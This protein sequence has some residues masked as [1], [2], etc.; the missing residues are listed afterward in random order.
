M[1]KW[2]QKE[3]RKKHSVCLIVFLFLE[4]AYHNENSRIRIFLMVLYYFF[5]S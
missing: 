5:L 1:I 2:F 3:R 4:I